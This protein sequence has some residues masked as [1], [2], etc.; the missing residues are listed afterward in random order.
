VRSPSLAIDRGLDETPFGACVRAVLHDV[1]F[2]AAEATD[3][4]FTVPLIYP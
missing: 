2:S 3:K 1:R 4:S